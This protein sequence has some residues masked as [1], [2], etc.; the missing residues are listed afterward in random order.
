MRHLFVVEI[1]VIK[2]DVV[3]YSGFLLM[4]FGGGG[5]GGGGV[6]TV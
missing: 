5:G 4:R 1:I 2:A 3:L 6:S